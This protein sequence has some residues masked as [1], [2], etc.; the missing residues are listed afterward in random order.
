MRPL[1]GGRPP[2]GARTQRMMAGVWRNGF[3]V[4][5]RGS[6][7]G[8]PGGLLALALLVTGG[9]QTASRTWL[10]LATDE[11]VPQFAEADTGFTPPTRSLAT[12]P[13]Q[14]QPAARVD[15][16]LRILHV[17]VPRG[18]YSPAATVWEHLREDVFDSETRRQL[19]SNGV[20]V[21]VGRTERWEVV[22]EIL[23]TIEGN[24]VHELPPV[25]TPS[26]V[27][28]A[29]ELDLDPRDHTIFYLDRDGI[30]S[31]QTWP[32]SQRVLRVAYT[33]DTRDVNQVFLNVVPEI[34]QRVDS[35]V[36]YTEAGWIT[37][38]RRRG[39]AFSAAALAVLLGPGEFVLLAPGEKAGVS[40]LVGGVFLT[41]TLGDEPYDSYVFLR[42]DVTY[43]SQRR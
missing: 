38:P 26:G 17:Q 7:G 22:R 37:G 13:A 20:R 9:C 30:L 12:S 4:L 5:G 11:P 42:T 3:P 32:A 34:R 15:V 28:L 25:R 8:G 29:L 41:D 33:L 18:R 27:P 31:G 35:G 2:G 1:D 36:S 40:G 10:D 24:R 16:L 23:D 21:G 43:V 6:A 14:R 19:Y 39:R